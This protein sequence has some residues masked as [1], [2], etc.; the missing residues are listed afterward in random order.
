MKQLN[1][2]IRP[3]GRSFAAK[4]GETILDAALRS[5]IALPYG[6]RDGAC[7]TCKGKVLSGE[8]DRGQYSKLA[9][10]DL[11]KS[12]GFALFCQA[13]PL[14]DLIL[15]VREISAIKG[16]SIKKI[17][18]KVEEL[19]QA[20]HDVMIVKL[21]LPANQ[22]MQFLAGQYIDFLL[23]DGERRSFS[24]ANAP[25]D[26]E[27]IELHI[28]KVDD[29][30][31]SEFVFSQLKEKALLRIEGPHGSFF[32]R[33]E[34]PRPIIIMAGGTGF[35]PAK[36]L[37]EQAFHQ[38]LQRDIYLYWGVRSKRDLYMADLPE[39]WQAKHSN[40]RYTPVLSDPQ[41]ED[42]WTGRTGL[43]HEAIAADFSSLR[44]YDVYA[45]GPPAMVY[46]GRDVFL[47]KGLNPDNCF[48]DAFEY[49]HPITED[50]KD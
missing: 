6:C 16:I 5:G 30:S 33:D 46:A 1:I 10:S 8:V 20:N 48:S 50:K 37:I 47:T 43:V 39:Q 12:Q 18:A 4:E 13:R 22:R 26:D 27:F 24:I 44:E 7:G 14:S 2:E 19:H 25:H 34:S 45:A 42:H 17:P 49:Q 23:K 38:G 31:F 9:L 3:S 15:E 32:L 21:R 29:G 41:T 11:Q 35:A 40:F 28:R 36:S